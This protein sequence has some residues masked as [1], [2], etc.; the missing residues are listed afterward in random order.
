MKAAPVKIRQ[1]TES[2]W[3]HIVITWLK[4]FARSDFSRHIDVA[5]YRANHKRLIQKFVETSDIIL[6]VDEDDES[7]IFGYIVFEYDRYKQETVLHYLH[8]KPKFRQ[9]G[10]GKR[11]LMLATN[12]ETFIITHYT[13][14]F[15][16]LKQTNYKYDPYLFLEEK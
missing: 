5:T 13:K 15:K 11:L 16:W 7:F 4:S 12:Q 9:F 10:I 14:P 8:V 1:A 2:D 6:A 3:P